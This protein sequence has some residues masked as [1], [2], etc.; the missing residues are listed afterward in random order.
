[1]M[2]ASRGLKPKE[3]CIEHRDVVEQRDTLDVIRVGQVLGSRACCDQFSLSAVA[4]GLD[5]IAQVLPELD[6]VSSA[7]KTARHANDRN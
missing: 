5:A 7:G 2:D 4:D 3:R 1:M 6:R